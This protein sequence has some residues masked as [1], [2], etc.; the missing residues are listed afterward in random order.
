M[1]ITI[2]DMM[3][4]FG[5]MSI[6]LVIGI[7][8]KA[9]VPLIQKTF[10]P[11][12]FIAGI[13]LLILGPS[14][15]D[16]LP[17]SDWL[18][19]YPSLL[20]AVVFAAIP[21]GAAR[22]DFREQSSRVR[23]V[24]FYGV[25]ALMLFYA[26]GLIVTQT[27]LTPV[28]G[29]PAGVGMMLGVGF[30]GGHG[31]AAAI[32]EAFAALGWQEATDIGYTAAT[33]GMVVAILGGMMIIKRGAEKNETNYITGFKDLPNE[34]R[35]GLVPS[36]KRLP[37]GDVTFSPNAVDPLLAHA[38][39]IGIA[40]LLAYGIQNGLESVFTGLS[41]PLFSMAIIAGLLVQFGLKTTGGSEY[42]DK[43]IMDRISGTATDLIVIF[44]IA[45][46]N[47]TVV[48]DYVVLLLIL[49]SIGIAAA[50]LTF[51][52]LA[53][54]TFQSHW[55]ENAVFNW[56]YT[57]GTVAMGVALLK[58]VDPNHRSGAL[59]DY[60]VA[61]LGIMPFEVVTLAILP[62]ILMS[63]FGWTYTIFTVL[64]CATLLILFRQKNWINRQRKTT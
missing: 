31:S 2:W 37:M 51:R 19:T 40:I 8:L 7:I 24:W 56:G 59:T 62:G 36:R 47:L 5:I 54:R 55:F 26:I 38:G 61:Y 10:M 13:L 49:F 43:R 52:L 32:G 53:A 44:G 23:S 27:F 3:V 60:G 11:A 18:G 20:I 57:T 42:V 22:A 35:T 41:V 25:F 45:S 50:Y 63:G 9:K 17:F 4:D 29:A 14:A 58:M 21:I 33:I 48:A 39:I 6:A 34:L 28:M 46:I 12:S 16:I 15:F 30:F 1:D 64:V